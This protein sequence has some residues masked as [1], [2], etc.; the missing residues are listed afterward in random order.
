MERIEGDRRV[1]HCDWC[2]IRLDVGR[3][4]QPLR[5]LPTGWLELAGRRHA[6]PL[7]AGQALLPFRN[8]AA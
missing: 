4:G 6:C 3:A 5:R 7:H 1:L 8:R 2:P